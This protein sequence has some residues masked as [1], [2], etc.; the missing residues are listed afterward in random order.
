MSKGFDARVKAYFDSEASEPA[1]RLILDLWAR[2]REQ[3]RSIEIYLDDIKRL[4]AEIELV[5]K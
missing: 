3:Q 5:S 1:G 2:V 4:R